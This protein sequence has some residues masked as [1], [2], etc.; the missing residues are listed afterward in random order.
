MEKE[1]REGYK[2]TELGEI[3]TEWEIKRLDD[4]RDKNDKYSFVGGPF[5]SDL[6]SEHYTDKGIRV[7]QLQNICEGYFN[8]DYKIYTSIEKADQLIKCNIYPDELIIAKM[9]EPVA[10]ACKIP[11]NEKRYLMCSD[12]IRL[13]VDKQF[14]NTDYIMYS[15]NSEYFRKNAIL[16]STGSTRMRIGLNELKSLPII[17]P[18]L[19]EQK[20]ISQILSS[21]DNEINEYENKKQ[22]LEELKKGLMQQ[23][24]TGKIR[25]V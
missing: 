17:L 21:L 24:L 16:N 25:I 3:P 4:I 2:M 9:A 19:E 8:N 10:R 7:I 11:N 14:N 22:K 6:K 12:G 23:L 20:K 18:K 13:V 1:V 15:I 5:G